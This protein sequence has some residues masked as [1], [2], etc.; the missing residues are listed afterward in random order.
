[1]FIWIIQLTVKVQNNLLVFFFLE[2]G[3]GSRDVEGYSIEGPRP[4]SDI[5][6]NTVPPHTP[7]DGTSL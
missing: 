4:S 3:G 5:M 2:G 7:L 6:M 1:M